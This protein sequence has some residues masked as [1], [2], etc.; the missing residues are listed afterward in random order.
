MFG[1]SV[2]EKYKHCPT[3]RKVVDQLRALLSAYHVTPNELRE[4][5]I[6]A[7]TMHDAENIRP[8]FITRPQGE[9]LTMEMLRYAYSPVSYPA[10]F[11]GDAVDYGTASGR[12]QSSMPNFTEQDKRSGLGERRKSKGDR[13]DHSRKE[14]PNPRDMFERHQGEY[15][16]LGR[17]KFGDRRKP[18]T[19]AF[20][21]NLHVHCFMSGRDYNVCRCGVSDTYYLYEYGK[22][23]KTT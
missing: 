17:S 13:R 6:L 12:V 21:P 2:E 10:M 15:E 11:G 9:A 7:A 8:L 5:V 23:P 14:V 22:K 4:A 3:F 1:S 16:F 19:I 20:D 18:V